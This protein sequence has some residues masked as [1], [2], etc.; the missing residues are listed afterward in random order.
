MTAVTW[1]STPGLVA[2]QTR[3]QLLASVRSPVGMFFTLG[4]PLIM[5]VLFNALFGGGTVSTPNG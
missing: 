2:E 1:P 4:L 5:L 3:Y